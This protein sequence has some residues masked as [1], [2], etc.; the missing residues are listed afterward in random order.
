MNKVD[1]FGVQK[2]SLAR[3]Q[4]SIEALYDRTTDIII[5]IFQDAIDAKTNTPSLTICVSTQQSFPG[6][7]IGLLIR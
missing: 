5:G 2:L 6:E 3:I 7:T 1:Y 4:A